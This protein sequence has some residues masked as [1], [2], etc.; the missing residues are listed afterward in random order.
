[1]TPAQTSLYWREWAAAKRIAR[2]EESDRHVLHQQAL[3]EPKSSK[4]FTNA[5]FDKVLAAFR[6]LSQPASLNGQLRQQ[7]QPRAR[8]EQRIRSQVKCLSLFLHAPERYTESILHAQHRKTANV[9]AGFS[10]RPAPTLSLSLLN[11][12]D[13]THL[14]STLSRVLSTKR[15]AFNKALE[16]GDK[17][18]LDLPFHS[19]LQHVTGDTITEHEMCLLAEVD[20]FR[21]AEGSDCAQCRR[22][23]S[24]RRL[25]PAAPI[26]L[27]R[28][29]AELVAAGADDSDNAPF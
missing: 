25:Q 13:L 24:S 11:E 10:L 7:G 8:L 3:G 6:A 12:R 16:T 17:A 1:M 2:L 9:A 29:P 20:C 26:N 5:D 14:R 23:Q 27:N 22:A 18:A 28:E 19:P 15:A 4:A 21:H